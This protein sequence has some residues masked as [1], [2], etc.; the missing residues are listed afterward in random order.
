MEDLT[1]ENATQ[2]PKFMR[3]P[4]VERRRLLPLD[5]CSEW[6]CAYCVLKAETGRNSLKRNRHLLTSLRK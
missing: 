6:T 4:T 3:C 2:G 5:T 1:E